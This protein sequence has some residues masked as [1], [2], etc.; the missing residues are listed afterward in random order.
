MNKLIA[1]KKSLPSRKLLLSRQL[2]E[3]PLELASQSIIQSTL[4]YTVIFTH[5]VIGAKPYNN[6][7]EQLMRW[8]CERFSTCDVI[9]EP[10]HV[11]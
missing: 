9:I 10:Y 7:I 3:G 5:D 8:F 2:H 1:I 6:E 4:E 11:F